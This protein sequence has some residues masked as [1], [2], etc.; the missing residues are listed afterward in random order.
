MAATARQER[1]LVMK[2]EK[3]KQCV[4]ITPLERLRAYIL[5]QG[6]RGLKTLAGCFKRIDTNNDRKIDYS[7]FTHA[8]HAEGIFVDPEVERDCFNEI[9]T[10]LTGYIDFDEFVYALRPPMSRLRKELVH[11]AFNKL[12]SNGDGVI[13]SADLKG[14]YNGRKHPKYLNGTWTEEQVFNEWL[15][16]F[17]GPQ[18]FSGVVM[19]L[20]FENYYAG[21]SAS[22]DMD[23]YFDLMMRQAWRL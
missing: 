9:D 8:L 16:S 7:E 3:L 2:M 12:D 23:I 13:T 14:V 5:S 21:V 18:N 4:D 6:V 19:R 15:N 22:I 20:E 11:R 10:D 17:N 1:E